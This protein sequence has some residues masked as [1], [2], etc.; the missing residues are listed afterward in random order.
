MGVVTVALDDDVETKLREVAK[1]KG[2][3]GKAISDAT[4]QWL[5]NQRQEALKR[6]LIEVMQKARPM[7]KILIK[8]REELYDR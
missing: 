1:G 8:K 4:K 2:A 7:G 5:E 3:L 6:R